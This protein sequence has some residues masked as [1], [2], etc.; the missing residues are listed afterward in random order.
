MIGCANG[1]TPEF[2]PTYNVP[3]EWQ[4][5][6]DTFIQEARHRGHSYVIE[7]L[8]IR[9]DEA[10]SDPVCGQC[11]DAR[12]EALVQKIISINPKA[13][14]WTNNQELEAL[15]FHELGHCVLGRA[16]LNALLPNG[17]PKSMMISD[18]NTV[19]APCQYDIGGQPCDRAFKRDYYLDELFDLNTPV[20]AWAKK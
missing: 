16:H 11:N 8:I 2:R 5:L 1:D 12:K 6:I 10:L 9:Y 3:E 7:N 18:D 13:T 17:D 20:P 4:P 19:Y 15:I 14:C